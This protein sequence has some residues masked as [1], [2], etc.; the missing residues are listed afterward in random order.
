MQPNQQLKLTERAHCK[1]HGA[2]KFS[3]N[4]KVI[5]NELG[6]LGSS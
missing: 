5:S 6:S 1:L 2:Q 4:L 3:F